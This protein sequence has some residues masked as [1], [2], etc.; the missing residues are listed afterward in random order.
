MGRCDRNEQALLPGAPDSSRLVQSTCIS[1]TFEAVSGLCDSL[2]DHLIRVFGEERGLMLRLGLT[3][4]MTNVA[5]H[6]YDRSMTGWLELGVWHASTEWHFVLRDGG[7]PIPDGLLDAADGSVF[8]FNPDQLD[9]VPEGGMGL[10][11]IRMAF[12]SVEYLPSAHANTLILKARA[13]R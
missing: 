13:A 6:G 9:E 8:N 2:S 12:D 5:E 3:E 4:A 7:R 10:S 11:L 1:A